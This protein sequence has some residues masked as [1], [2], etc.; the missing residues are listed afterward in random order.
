MDLTHTDM[1][2]R[3][4]LSA[5]VQ[6]GIRVIVTGNVKDFGVDD[7]VR[8]GVSV[9]HP[10]LF[11]SQVLSPQIYRD[12]VTVWSSQRARSGTTPESLH[13]LLA[14]QHAHTLK[15]EV[16]RSSSHSLSATNADLPNPV[17]AYV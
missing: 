11:L 17:S 3:H 9:V 6:A 2:D 16:N 7:L 8:V 5:A 14:G 10:D 1:K 4:V 12:V 15:L 13:S